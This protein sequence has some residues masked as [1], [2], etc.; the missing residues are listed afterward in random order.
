[1][2]E[3]HTDYDVCA[4]MAVIEDTLGHE[5]KAMLLELQGQFEELSFLWTTDLEVYFKEFC[6]GCV[7][8]ETEHATVLDLAKY[9]DGDHQVLGHRR[10]SRTS[11]SPTDVGWLR[12]NTQPIKAGARCHWSGRTSH[13]QLTRS[14]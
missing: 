6:A 14:F 2:R 7:L 12:I 13:V 9:D 5:R 1:M 3:M 10:K 8:V 4:L 11:G